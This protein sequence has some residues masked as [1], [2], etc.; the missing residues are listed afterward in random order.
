MAVD[1]SSRIKN[2]DA[3]RTEECIR[4]GRQTAFRSILTGTPITQG[5]LDL[6]AQFEFLN[7]HIFGMG[8]YYSF[9][10]RYAIMGGWENKEIIGYDN[11]DEM[12]ATVKP[13]IFEASLKDMVD[14]PPKIYQKRD[15]FVSKE[16]RELLRDIASGHAQVD[17]IEIE[18][19]NVLVKLLRMQQ[20]VNGFYPEYVRDPLTGKKV[21]HY[22]NLRANPKLR[23]LEAVLEENSY[24]AIIWAKYHKDLENIIPILKDKTVQF[25]GRVPHEQRQD[26]VNKFQNGDAKYFVGNPAAGGLGLTLTAARLMV[27]YSNSFSLEERLQSEE[28]AHRIGQEHPVTYVDLVMKGTVD[29][30]SQEAIKTKT[31]IADLVRNKIR[32]TSSQRFLDDLTGSYA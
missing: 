7:T 17:D 13:F 25:H 26:I 6:Y 15:V 32:E 1:E 30:L 3:K 18:I 2:A 16:Q 8:D 21:A 10:N 29:E 19:Q 27:Y 5:P 20:V 24:Q 9:R 28:R 14:L 12:A 23:E 31:E 4:I 11:M 22:H